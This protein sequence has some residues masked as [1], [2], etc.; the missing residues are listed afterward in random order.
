VQLSPNATW[1]FHAPEE[2]P[3]RQPNDDPTAGPFVNYAYAAQVELEL[4]VMKLVRY[5]RSLSPKKRLCYAGGLALNI[6]ANRLI[7]ES[8]EFED[9]FVQP[10]ASDSGIPLGAALLGYYT[11]LGG[12]RRWQMP[13]AFLAHEHSQGELESAIARWSGFHQEYDHR[14]LA[15]ILCNNYLAAWFQGASEYGPRALGHRSILCC[16]RHPHMKAYLNREVKPREMFRPFAP[17]VPA[18]RQAEFFD[19]KQSSP[20]MLLNATVLPEKASLMPAIVHADGTAR[21]QSIECAAQPELHSLLMEVGRLAATPVLLNTSLNLA[22]EPI[23]E[24][25]ADA[26]DLFARS[27]LDVLVLGRHLLSKQPLSNLLEQQNP[28]LAAALSTVS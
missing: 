16:P 4:G 10:A 27:R 15:R 20:Y 17:I 3:R 18:E 19:L 22:G 11:V 7:L 1:Q 9:L 21:L 5:A 28:G 6:V 13:H 26:I 25:P 24:T 12:K 8:G 2:M 23:V 14:I